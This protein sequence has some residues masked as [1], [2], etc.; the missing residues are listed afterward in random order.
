[1]IRLYYWLSLLLCPLGFAADKTYSI[2]PESTATFLAVGKPSLLKIRGEGAHPKGSLTTKDNLVSGEFTVK[3]DD[4]V[5][6]ISKRDSHMKEHYLETSKTGNAN[7]VFSLKNLDAN[8]V[9]TAKK[10]DFVGELSL[11]GQ[12]KPIKDGKMNTELKDG[13]IRI[14]AEFPLS[15]TEFGIQVPTFAGVTVANEVSVSV[16]LKLQ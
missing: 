4:F 2:A 6:G 8:C 13:N 9:N 14:T 5:T 7:A 3:L 12:T 16:D 15:I 11:H 1:M 10:C